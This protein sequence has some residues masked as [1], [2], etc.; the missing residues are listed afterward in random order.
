MMRR[1]D[2]SE[3]KESSIVPFIK[4]LEVGYQN[5]HGVIWPGYY[6]I[7]DIRR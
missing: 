3:F 1:L 5:G 4:C 7:F 6:A 2:V